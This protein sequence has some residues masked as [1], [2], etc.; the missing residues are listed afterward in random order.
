LVCAVKPSPFYDKSGRGEKTK[1]EATEAGRGI[2]E[3]SY[4]NEKNIR[5]RLKNFDFP[6]ATISP[7]SG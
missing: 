4:Y 2:A 1:F 7:R 6:D 5:E 3:R